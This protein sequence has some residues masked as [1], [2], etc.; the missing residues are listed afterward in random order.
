[1]FTQDEFEIVV[2]ELLYKESTSY[3]M[4]CHIIIK[5]LGP[6]VSNWCRNNSALRGRGYEEDLL[7]EL[8]LYLIKVTVDKF[9][10]KKDE[11]GNLKYRRDPAVFG[12]WLNT[13]ARNKIID[14]AIEVGENDNRTV[15]IDDEFDECQIIEDDNEDKEDYTEVLKDAFSVVL[16]S[17]A[18]IYKILTWLA[19]SVIV[20][21]SDLTRIKA[22]D[23]VIQAFED[24]TLAD[25]YS[26]ILVAADKISWLEISDEQHRKII[27][28]LKSPW[29]DEKS[30]G[31]VTY[32]DFFMRYKGE[33]SP[34][35]SISD[36]VNRM[37]AEVLR[38][39]RTEDVS[40]PKN[41]K[42][43][44]TVCAESKDFVDDDESITKKDNITEG[45]S[46]NEP[47]DI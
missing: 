20:I 46:D 45:G 41:K 27:D 40:Q 8:C 31:E 28:S 23:A 30:Y 11:N 13:V 19:Q 16:A 21:N 7:Q 3:D 18:G 14:W 26:M 29:D 42:R 32:R 47:F 6:K 12:K 5:F 39:I 34:K 22:R 35:K 24:K 17:N 1:M 43:K 4:L 44:K 25:M 37:D 2:N 33:I 15:N 38:N 10:L 36:W 9:F